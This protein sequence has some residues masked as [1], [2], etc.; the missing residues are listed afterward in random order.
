MRAS[1]AGSHDVCLG[2]GAVQL[3]LRE[4]A[5]RLAQKISGDASRH[6]KRGV[7]GSRSEHCGWVLR[8]AGVGSKSSGIFSF[9]LVVDLP[10]L[11]A[12]P[13]AAFLAVLCRV[14]LQEAP[15]TPRRTVTFQNSVYLETGCGSVDTQILSCAEPKLQPPTSD[16]STVL[17]FEGCKAKKDVGYATWHKVLSLG[18]VSTCSIT[19]P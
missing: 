15:P 7:Q 1:R 5:K 9:V 3:V 13:V 11:Q 8:A 18:L 10:L 17:R 4:G 16:S 2:Q 6:L 12:Q 14:S 19:H